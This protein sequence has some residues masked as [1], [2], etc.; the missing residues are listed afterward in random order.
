MFSL[1][2]LKSLGERALVTFC[3]TLGSLL[4]SGA[5]GLLDAPWEQSLSAA[6]LAA[7]LSV[8]VS[9]GGGATT[10]SSSPA[11][12]S[13]ETEQELANNAETINNY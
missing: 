13:K 4:G 9:V 3:A 1:A 2:Y 7:I 6:G 10:T 5:V 11:L 8:L 12:T